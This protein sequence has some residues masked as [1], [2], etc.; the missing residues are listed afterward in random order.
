LTTHALNP[1]SDPFALRALKHLDLVVLALALPVFL[2][3]GFPLLG[4]GAAAAAWIAQ[5]VI[6]EQANR[7]ARRSDD[8]RT[9]A[10]LLTG[11]MIGRGWLVALA[12]FGAGMVER[13]A[14]LTAAVLSI[15]LFTMWFTTQMATRPFEMGGKR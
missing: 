9:V 2:L 11:S 5:R 8:P 3:A 15:L 12:I 13:E 1:S 14:G 4:W 10:G 7:R 6:A